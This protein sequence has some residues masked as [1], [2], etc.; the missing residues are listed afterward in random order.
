MY[1]H[2]STHS[3]TVL[4]PINTP[5]IVFYTS[6]FILNV[7][8]AALSTWRLL[9]H[10]QLYVCRNVLFISVQLLELPK[11]AALCTLHNVSCGFVSQAKLRSCS[12]WNQQTDGRI[13]LPKWC[14]KHNPPLRTKKLADFDHYMHVPPIIEAYLSADKK[15]QENSLNVES[16]TTRTIWHRVQHRVLHDTEPAESLAVHT[17]LC[18]PACTSDTTERFQP[19][20]RSDTWRQIVLHRQGVNQSNW[21]S[22]GAYS[23]SNATWE[24]GFVW[25]GSGRR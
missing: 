11:R 14:V 17:A 2:R 10:L 5:H 20:Q 21:A 8:M 18:L 23:E 25:K 16:I 9:Q 1:T 4:P 22:C 15:L 24:I 6:Y 19:F 7:W 12:S 13:S 3:H